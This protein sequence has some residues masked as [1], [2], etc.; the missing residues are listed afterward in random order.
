M[1]VKHRVFDDNEEIE[2]ITIEAVKPL[3]NGLD[4]L[5]D[6]GSDSDSDAAPEA[7]DLNS[8]RKTAQNREKQA[9]LD[10]ER[11]ISEI[12]DLVL[13]FQFIADIPLLHF[14]SKRA[15]RRKTNR[16]REEVKQT[17]AQQQQRLSTQSKGKGREQQQD[18]DGEAAGEALSDAATTSRQRPASALKAAKLD[19]SLFLQAEEALQQ[20][21]ENAAREQKQMKTEQLSSKQ[22]SS[23]RDKRKA[24]RKA[25][26]E[27]GLK[28]KVI[29]YV[30][31][32]LACWAG[33]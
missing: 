1:G 2:D 4:S 17:Q 20:A 10:D 25:T 26:R 5:S 30:S 29:G 11:C 14:G 21:R 28:K 8:A 18:D 6:S 16:R 31:V 3:A 22:A 9:K 13:P 15:A 24:V 19:P 7:V 33:L 32:A 23:K 12:C 27:G